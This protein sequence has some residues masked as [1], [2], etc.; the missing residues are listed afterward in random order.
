[1]SIDMNAPTLV[2]GAAGFIGY[3]LAK[4]LLNA[5]HRIAGFDNM[6][7]YYDPELKEARLRELQQHTDFEFVKG[8]L[9]D[10]QAVGALFERYRPETVV[11][12][13]AQAGVRYSIVCGHR[14]AVG[15]IWVQAEHAA[16]GRAAAVCGVVCRV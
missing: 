15:R 5:G 10:K 16:G 3:H 7:A 6:N 13:A 9:A 1:M 8:D 2:T 11:H 12:L 14:Q 4:Q